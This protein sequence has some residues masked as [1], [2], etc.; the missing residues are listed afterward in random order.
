MA[1]IAEEGVEA[2]HA[3][4]LLQR[5]QGVAL[6]GNQLLALGQLA[7]LDGDALR[8]LVQPDPAVGI[9]RDSQLGDVQE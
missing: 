1:V 2:V 7:D 6:E 5:D 8:L 9:L 3:A 4:F